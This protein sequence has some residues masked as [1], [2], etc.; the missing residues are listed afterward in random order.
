MLGRYQETW[1]R[2]RWQGLGKTDTLLRASRLC[3][4]QPDNFVKGSGGSY[5]IS[6]VA[7]IQG[8]RIDVDLDDE[9]LDVDDWRG[10]IQR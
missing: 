5:E 4:P 2:H 10:I 1:R 7:N 3:H 6:P 9:D 8:T